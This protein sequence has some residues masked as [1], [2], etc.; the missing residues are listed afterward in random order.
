MWTFHEDSIATIHEPKK[1]TISRNF[2]LFVRRGLKQW[3]NEREF[4]HRDDKTRR[5]FSLSAREKNRK[6][7]KKKIFFS[8]PPFRAY[9]ILRR[10]FSPT[11]DCRSKEAMIEFLRSP[12]KKISESFYSPIRL[13]IQ[14]FIIVNEENIDQW[15]RTKKERENVEDEE[16]ERENRKG[17][18][19]TTTTTTN[20]VD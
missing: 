20:I 1:T 15:S 12:S 11:P 8:R 16:R 10:P 4:H 5:F 19:H 18:I 9:V 14:R 3:K 13:L 2:S 7:K 6:E 17:L